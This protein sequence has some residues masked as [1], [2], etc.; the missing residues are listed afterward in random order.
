MK[1]VSHDGEHQESEMENLQDMFGGGIDLA[2][3][4]SGAGLFGGGA[5][6]ILVAFFHGVIKRFIVRALATA[7]LTGCGFLFLLNF[8]GFEIVPPEEL[9]DRFPFGQG[10]DAQEDSRESTLKGGRPDRRYGLKSPFRDN[11]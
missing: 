7:V 11:G 3:L 5:S 4:A 9:N 8:L 1:I 6:A 10:F 2:A